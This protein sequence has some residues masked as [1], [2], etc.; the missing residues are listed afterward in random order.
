M[1]TEERIEQ[2]RADLAEAKLEIMNL[3]RNKRADYAAQALSGL[4][5][6]FMSNPERASPMASDAARWAVE[7][8]D[9]LLEELSK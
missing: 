8:T 3:K 5:S 7:Y 9:A 4:L 1:S 6:G 2:L